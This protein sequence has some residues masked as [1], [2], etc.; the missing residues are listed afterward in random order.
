MKILIAGSRSINDYTLI[1][2]KC[3]EA[4]FTYNQD[5]ITIISGCAGGVDKF[6]ERFADDMTLDGN[7]VATCELLRRGHND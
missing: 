7:V 2:R 1:K 5:E 3:N 4:L 6:G